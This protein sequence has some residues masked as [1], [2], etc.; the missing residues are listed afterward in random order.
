MR[1]EVDDA[2]QLAAV[3]GGVAGGVDVD[4]FEIVGFDFGAEA[5]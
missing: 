4:G 1:V 3:L 2:A 5:G